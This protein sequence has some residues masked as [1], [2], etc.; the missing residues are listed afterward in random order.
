M[1]TKENKVFTSTEQESSY[2]ERKIHQKNSTNVKEDKSLLE[3]FTI[4]YLKPKSFEK[5]GKLYE[6]LG[7]KLFGKYFPNGGSYWT[8]KKKTLHR[9]TREEQKNNLKYFIGDVTETELIHSFI[10]VPLFTIAS[11][12]NLAT[13]NYAEAG[14]LTILNLLINFYPI[15][16]QR[17]NRNKANKILEKYF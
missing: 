9:T 13:E 14:D 3:R 12:V 2:L 8:K 4:W 7:V 10:F 5:S 17:Y 16:N 1:N 15:I 6:F 11:A